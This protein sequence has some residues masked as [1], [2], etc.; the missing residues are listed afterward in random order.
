M[1]ETTL[2]LEYRSGT[3]KGKTAVT[4][5]VG[6]RVLEVA[7]LNVME[8][9]ERDRFASDLVDK[10]PGINL[11]D[12]TEELTR[13]AHEVVKSLSNDAERESQAD[14]LVQ[15]AEGVDLFHTPGGHDSN[16]FAVIRVGDPPHRETWSLRSS[17]FKRWLSRNYYAEYGKAPNAQA[18]YDALGVL[19]GKA[20]FD[21]PEH[22]TGI[23][24][25]EHDGAIWLDLVDTEWR[26]VEITPR[27]WRVVDG[28]CVPVRFMRRKGM[29]PLPVPVAGGRLDEFRRFVNLPDDGA[30]ALVVSF[31]LSG[32]RPKGPYPVLVV[33]GEHGSAKSTLCRFVRALIDPNKV[34]LRRPPKDERDL[35]IAAANSWMIGFD[36]L[37]GL[38]AWMSDALCCLS[39]GGGFAARELFSDGEE[40]LFDATRPIMANGI[41]DFAA[42]PDLMDRA[43]HITLPVISD[44]MRQEEDLLYAQFDEARPRI[45]GALLEVVSGALREWPHVNLASKP[46]MADFARWATAAETSL[47][48][49]SGT[50]LGFYQVNRSNSHELALEASPIA[51]AIVHLMEERS[52]W[53]GT[54]TDL[55]QVLETDYVDEKTRRARNWPATPRALSSQLTRIAP[56]LRANGIEVYREQK[57]SRR[58]SITVLR[59]IAAEPSQQS[60]S[61]LAGA[62]PT[63]L[64]SVEGDPSDGRSDGIAAATG[65]PSQTVTAV[66]PFARNH[67]Q[68]KRERSDG[69]DGNY[70]EFQ[71]MA[72]DPQ[73]QVFSL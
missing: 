18:V 22:Q 49:T 1:D 11:N 54:T 59:R 45:L 6:Q 68:S 41:D 5:K 42:R 27:G 4:C 25:A 2:R 66:N 57:R 69:S 35:M 40:K 51:T 65:I 24:I 58:G 44:K 56:N 33:N 16:G 64:E 47:G 10:Y 61:S 19:E 15:L 67:L 17:T 26:A 20:I 34:S 72:A 62:S 23:R 37:S 53:E 32:L 13:V 29:L 46:R 52:D 36:N 3:R 28:D 43:L 48:W 12:L 39:T 38:S 50:F 30:W 71:E 31:L 63:Q 21:G 73:R 8:P 55:Q 70:V 9:L 14:R 60:Q 7:E